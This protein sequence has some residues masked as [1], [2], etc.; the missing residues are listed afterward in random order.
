MNP[1]QLDNEGQDET[2]QDPI[3]SDPHLLYVWTR[4]VG[5]LIALLAF[6]VGFGEVDLDF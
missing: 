6:S 3:A 5:V 1:S 4:Y 2:Q